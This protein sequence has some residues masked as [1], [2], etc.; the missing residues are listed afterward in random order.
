MG[1][2]YLAINRKECLKK[3]VGMTEQSFAKRK[4]DHKYDA[5]KRNKQTEFH[6]AIRKH[7]IEAFSRF[8]LGERKRRIDLEKFEQECIKKY[9][10][11]NNG[12]NRQYRK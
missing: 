3:Y 6:E 12:Y 9:D 5:I 2:V 11:V 10:T 8:I 4:S 1:I 7:G